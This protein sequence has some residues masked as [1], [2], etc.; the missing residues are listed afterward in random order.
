MLNLKP[1][2]SSSVCDSPV[3]RM[4]MNSAWEVKEWINLCGGSWVVPSGRELM[5]VVWAYL[6]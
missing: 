2:E 4:L 5:K 1:P 6:S 3:E